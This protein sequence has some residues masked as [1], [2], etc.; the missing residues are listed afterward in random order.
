MAEV[1][2]FVDCREYPSEM[3]CSLYI[4]GTEDEVLRAATEHAV[5]AHKHENSPEL[6]NSLRAAMKDEPVAARL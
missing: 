6:V 4:S 2:K 5:S 1:R 3:N